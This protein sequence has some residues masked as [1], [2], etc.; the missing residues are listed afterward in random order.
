MGSRPQDAGPETL[1]RGVLLNP[2]SSAPH[3][4]VLLPGTGAG[5]ASLA[6]EPALQ[7]PPC[8]DSAPHLAAPPPEHTVVFLLR[9]LP[10][11]PRE[12]FA[13]WQMTADDFQPVLGVL[14]DGQSGARAVARLSGPG[15]SVCSPPG[16]LSSSPLPCSGQEVSDLLPPRPH[17]RLARGHL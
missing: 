5:A 8:S 14:L 10:E 7:M 2:A 9:V 15:Q 13:L 12:T 6:P 11:T 3:T 17:G 1:D 4:P 16:P